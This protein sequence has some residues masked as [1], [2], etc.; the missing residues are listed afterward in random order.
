MFSDRFSRDILQEW[1]WSERYVT[2][3]EILDYLNFVADRMDLRKDIQFNARVTSA[4]YDE[5]G[6]RWHLIMEDGTTASA[7]YLITAVG[8]L[9]TT[10][11]PSFP[12]LEDFAGDWYHTGA[13][14]HHAVDFTGKRVAVIGTGCTGIQVV[15]EI[16]E[17]ASKV[18]VFQRTPNYAIPTWNGPLDSEATQ[19]V[20]HDYEAIW[21]RARESGFGFPYHAS[22]RAAVDSSP[23]E[24][25]RIYQTAWAKGGF[26]F[27]IETFNDFLVKQGE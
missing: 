2:Q 3:P 18:F 26:A 19:E 24:R 14:P 22:E 23:E 21:Q 15:P 9:S 17:Q 27:G 8:C 7:R 1:S 12:G 6:N 4:I 25:E 13:W 16:A 5:E 20:K 11:M 10:N